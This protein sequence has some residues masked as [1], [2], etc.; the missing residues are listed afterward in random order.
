MAPIFYLALSGTIKGSDFCDPNLD[1]MLLEMKP[2][3]VKNTGKMPPRAPIKEKMFFGE[4]VMTET[5]GF[6]VMIRLL[7]FGK[8][9]LEDWGEYEG[10]EKIEAS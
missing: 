8:Y 5:A 6:T 7:C 10:G 9:I 2:P 3:R 4:Y 1:Q